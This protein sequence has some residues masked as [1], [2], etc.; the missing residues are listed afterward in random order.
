MIITKVIAD[1]KPTRR[2][3][4]WFMRQ[5]GRYLPEYRQVRSGFSNFIEFCQTPEAAAEVTLQPLKR[6]DIDAA[7]IFSDILIVPFALGNRVEFKPDHGPIL[8]KITSQKDVERLTNLNKHVYEKTAEAIKLTKN[9]MLKN[10]PSKALIGFAGAPWTV[11]AYMVQGGGSKNFHDTIKFVY[12]QPEV[13]D[14][15]IEVITNATIDH[16]SYQIEAGADLIKLFDSW[17]GLVSNNFFEKYCIKP[18]AKIVE[19]IKVRYP[20]VGIIGFPKG[21]NSIISQYISMTNVDCIAID[22]HMSLEQAIGSAQPHSAVVQGNLDNLLLAYGSKDDIQKETT[23]I[24]NA[25]K[26]HPHIFN[27]GHGMIPETPI[28]NVEKLIDA[29]RQHENN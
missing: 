19:A 6:F 15:L 16:L 24:L 25:A 14:L 29:I 18:I 10:F 28:E 22:Q 23:K 26:G 20:S 13:F 9:E 21:A 3:P 27:L 7:I 5:A 8:E 2:T 12:Q 4:V 17:A 1:R 11:A